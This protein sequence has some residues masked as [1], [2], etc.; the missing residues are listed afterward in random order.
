M[1]LQDN[2]PTRQFAYVLYSLPTE[3]FAYWTFNL[4]DISPTG[5][6]PY[7]FIYKYHWQRN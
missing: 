2:L 5:H 1:R 4:K 7:T 3:S 6:F